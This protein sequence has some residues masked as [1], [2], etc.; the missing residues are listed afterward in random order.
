MN[1]GK[2]SGEG[3]PST[4]R[5]KESKRRGKEKGGGGYLQYQMSYC[6]LKAFAVPSY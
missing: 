3:L 2:P 4:Q 6:L 1:P 5:H